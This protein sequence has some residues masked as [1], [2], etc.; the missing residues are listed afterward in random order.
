MNKKRFDE[1]WLCDG[2]TDKPVYFISKI[3]RKT[4]Y[5]TTYP[6]LFILYEKNGFVFYSKLPKAK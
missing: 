2:E 5:M 4:Y 1:K 3:D 6:K